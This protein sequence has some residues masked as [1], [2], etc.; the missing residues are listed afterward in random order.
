MYP[1]LYETK[2]E[3]NGMDETSKIL[4]GV[5]LADGTVATFGEIRYSEAQDYLTEDQRVQARINI[6]AASA[7]EIG[8]ISE[9]LDRIIEIQDSLIRGD[10]V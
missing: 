8:D 6:G 1:L 4:K 2:K 9:A 5:K 10:S 3:V 7:D